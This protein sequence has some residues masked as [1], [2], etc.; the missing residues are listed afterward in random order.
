MAWNALTAS[1]QV[2]F[3]LCQDHIQETI[4]YGKLPTDFSRPLGCNGKASSSLLPGSS[5]QLKR[6]AAGNTE[7]VLSDR[8]ATSSLKG[9]HRT[10]QA[11]KY[12]NGLSYALACELC[13]SRKRL[14]RRSMILDI[15]AGAGGVARACHA[16]GFNA[17]VFELSKSTTSDVC[18]YLF[19]DWVSKAIASQR[20]HAIMLATPCNSFSIAVSRSGR[21]LRSKAHPRGLPI[22]MTESEAERIRQGNKCLDAAIFVIAFCVRFR[23]PCILENPACSYLWHDP[24]LQSVLDGS[25][26]TTITSICFWSQMAKANKIRY[27]KFWAMNGELTRYGVDTGLGFFAKNNLHDSPSGSQTEHYHDDKK[28]TFWLKAQVTTPGRLIA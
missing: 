1:Q 25:A 6:V 18:S 15:F 20:I 3:Q 12:S 10:K 26:I 11:A 28:M 9:G 22:N 7:R 4:L 5:T 17:Y 27:H 24:A 8:A 13:W 19:Q 2:S 21:A 23:V 14:N 16:L